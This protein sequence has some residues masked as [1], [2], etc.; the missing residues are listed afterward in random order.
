MEVI[1]ERR[2][3][4]SPRKANAKGAGFHG[5]LVR[6][7]D[8]RGVMIGA[9]LMEDQFVCLSLIVRDESDLDVVFRGEK[10]VIA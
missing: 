9:A 1:T 3:G 4:S 7:V 10:V 5:G 2:T 6:L 8:S